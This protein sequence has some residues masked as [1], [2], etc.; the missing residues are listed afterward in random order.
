MTSKMDFPGHASDDRWGLILMHLNQEN[1]SR[2][3]LPIIFPYLAWYQWCEE[4]AY[5]NKHQKG[6]K[7]VHI[8]TN[9]FFTKIL[10]MIAKWYEENACPFKHQ[11]GMEDVHVHLLNKTIL[12]L[13]II[14]SAFHIM[15]VCGLLRVIMYV[16]WHS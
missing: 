7:D 12:L 2:T 3:N 15:C 9:P 13:S 8:S 10:A 11:K 5:P 16:P 6:F 14:T 4:D 1:L